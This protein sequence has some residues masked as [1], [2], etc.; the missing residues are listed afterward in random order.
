MMAATAPATEFRYRGDVVQLLAEEGTLRQICYPDGAPFWVK[1]DKL[2]AVRPK[3]INHH[4]IP[5]IAAD[6]FVAW[7]LTQPVMLRADCPPPFVTKLAAM[8]EAATGEALPEGT[9]HISV[10]ETDKSWGY[11][12][13]VDFPNPPAGIATPSNTMHRH[14]QRGKPCCIASNEFV[15]GLLALGL[16]FGSNQPL[17]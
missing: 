2:K 17:K 15:L 6:P 4:Q 5:D 12:L 16:R 8:Y 13:Y 7:L 10:L 3:R 11:S 9:Q 14:K 1:F